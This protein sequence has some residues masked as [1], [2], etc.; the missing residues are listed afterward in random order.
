MNGCCIDVGLVLMSW[1]VAEIKTSPNKH[2]CSHVSGNKNAWGR[3]RV[4]PSA[5][6]CTEQPNVSTSHAMEVSKDAMIKVEEYP[7]YQ[8]CPHVRHSF[9]MVQWALDEGLINKGTI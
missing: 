3:R 5:S 6:C 4:D 2:Q 7:G 8:D 9:N 1:P